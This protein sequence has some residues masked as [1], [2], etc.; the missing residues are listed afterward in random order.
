MSDNRETIIIV[1]GVTVV[2]DSV[3]SLN[4]SSILLNFLAVKPKEDGTVSFSMRK[5]VH[6]NNANRFFYIN[7]LLISEKTL[8]AYLRPDKH[9]KSMEIYP[10]P[11]GETL[12]VKSDE[13]MEN[14]KILD[15]S[16]REIMKIGKIDAGT[17]TLNLSSLRKGYYIM[18]SSKNQSFI[19]KN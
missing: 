17:S 19:L 16:G 9:L 7:S 4:N 5:G 12:T 1:S 15:V 18:K 6:N 14:V 11:V 3:N 13:V 8:T 10:N 2:S